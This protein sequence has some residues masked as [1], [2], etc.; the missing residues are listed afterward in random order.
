[1]R[2]STCL[3]RRICYHRRRGEQRCLGHV[4]R[5]QSH[6]G[7]R[8]V[9]ESHLGCG[10]RWCGIGNAL[11]CRRRNPLPPG[12]NQARGQRA[13]EDRHSG[14]GHLLGKSMAFLGLGLVSLTSSSR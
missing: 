4:L 10:T 11:V 7:Q 9:E 1:M 6:V 2:L 14:C 5:L 3:C 12:Q 8:M 13:V